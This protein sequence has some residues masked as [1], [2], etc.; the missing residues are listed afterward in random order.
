MKTVFR[1]FWPF[2][3]IFS[4]GIGLGLFLF[5]LRWLEISF[6]LM[7]PQPEWHSGAIAILFSILGFWFARKIW[8]RPQKEAS[9]EE[10]EKMEK[11][12]LTTAGIHQL[13]PREHQVL[14]LMA[15][16]KTNQEIADELFV[17]SNTVKTHTSRLYEKLE[18][19]RRTEAIQKARSLG[20]LS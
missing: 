20:V 11:P 9:M 16:G 15:F 18:V 7:K 2:R 6:I 3:T 8:D 13:S 17:S 10:P 5:I 1:F 19:K 14:Q 4:L 12:V